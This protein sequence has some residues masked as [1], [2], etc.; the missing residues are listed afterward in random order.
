MHVPLRSASSS[1]LLALPLAVLLATPAD[2]WAYLD[3]GTGSYLIQL[4]AA[5]ILAGFVTLRMYF[6]RVK[7]WFRA[8]KGGSDDSP[9]A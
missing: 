6:Q 3:A 8:K 4:A 2:A 9:S 7:D 1:M 5:G